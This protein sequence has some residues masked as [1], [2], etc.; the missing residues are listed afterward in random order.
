MT[1]IRANRSGDG[2]RNRFH[3][4]QG[5]SFIATNCS[6]RLLIRYAFQIFLLQ[7]AGTPGWVQEDGYDIAAKAGGDPPVREFP[8]MP[9]SLLEDRFQ[10]QTH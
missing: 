3:L 7:I 2:I 5:G 4:A 1:S 10:L 9:R 8:A 6:L